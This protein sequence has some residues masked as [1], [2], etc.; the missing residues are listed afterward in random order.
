LNKV[1]IYQFAE[2]STSVCYNSN[3]SRHSQI[4]EELGKL[5]LAMCKVCASTR[6]LGG[7]YGVQIWK[8]ENIWW[9][10]FF[11]MRSRFNHVVLRKVMTTTKKLPHWSPCHPKWTCR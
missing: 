4:P 2:Q 11:A 7:K 5:P 3:L 8:S 6:K 10:Q 1:P 9:L